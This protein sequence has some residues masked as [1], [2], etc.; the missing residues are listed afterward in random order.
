VANYSILIRVTAITKST[1]VA[2]LV[3]APAKPLVSAV[4]WLNRLTATTSV[5][6]RMWPGCSVGVLPILVIGV[7]QGHKGVMRY[8]STVERNLWK[9]K[10]KQ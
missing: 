1:A 5:T 2:Q 4:G 7:D 10:G 9:I 8:K 6:R 3:G